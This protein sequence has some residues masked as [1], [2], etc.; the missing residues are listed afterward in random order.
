MSQLKA[1][2]KKWEIDQCQAVADEINRMRGTDYIAI[3]SG[4][5]FPDVILT[6]A[7]KRHSCLQVEV[8][9]IPGDFMGRDDNHNELRVKEKLEASLSDKGL[10]HFQVDLGLTQE[11]RARG[12]KKSLVEQ[13]AGLLSEAVSNKAG[14]SRIRLGYGEIHRHSPE[15][16]TLVTDVSLL[17]HKLNPGPQVEVAVGQWL[18]SDGR[19]IEEGIKKKLKRYGPDTVKEVMLVLGVKAFVDTE[20]IDRFRTSNPEQSLPFSEIWIVTY[21]DRGVFCLKSST[22]DPAAA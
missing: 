6:S 19:W 10:Q 9:S 18:P 5:E 8:T 20:Q 14:A 22:P 15:L 3:C 4:R 17:R 12:I 2:K 16:A 11:A 13:L 21:Y 7:S 1:D